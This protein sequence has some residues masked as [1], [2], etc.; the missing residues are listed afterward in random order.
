MSKKPDDAARIAGL[1]NIL[2]VTNQQKEMPA[3]P[4]PATAAVAVA[5]VARGRKEQ[6]GKSRD[7]DYHQCGLY[8]RKTVFKQARRRLEDTEPDKDMSEL[9][10]ELIEQ[11]LGSRR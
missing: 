11:W 5:A 2:R 9:V 4:A 10:Q 7:P 1:T 3:A 6:V 8:I